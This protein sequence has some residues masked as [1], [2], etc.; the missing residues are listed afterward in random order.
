MDNIHNQWDEVDAVAMALEL[1]DPGQPYSC[2]TWGN[3]FDNSEPLIVH[4]GSPYYHWWEMF[5]NMYVPAHAF[6]D[7]NMT[8]HYKTNTLS[9]YTANQKIEEML[10]DCGECYIDGYPIGDN[11]TS[12]QSYQE[13]CCEEFGGVYFDNGDWDEFYC[14][15]SDATWVR[16]CGNP[17]GDDDGFVTDEDNCPND[18]NPSQDDTDGDGLGDACDDCPNMSGDINDDFIID[19]LDIVNVVNMILTGGINS[20]DFTDCEK[21]DADLDGNGTINILDAIQIINIVLGTSRAVVDDMD[22]YV[23]ASY[24]INDN[25]LIVKLDSDVSLSGI[26]LAFFSNFLLDVELSTV[27]SDIY[28]ATALDGD[29]QRFVAFSME[30]VSFDNNALELTIVDGSLLDIEDINIIAGD[31]QGKNIP[32]RWIAGEVTNFKI[33]D[34]YPNPFNPVTQIEYN[35]DQAGKLSLSVYNILGQEVAVLYNGQQVEG[36]Y[37]VTW[38]ASMFASGV[39]YIRMIMNGQMEITKAML[40]K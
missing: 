31:T 21:T 6:I 25:D 40:I 1:S 32:T 3:Q 33:A 39:Y 36:T 35:V 37:N 22:G 4:G 29:I 18:Y 15:G 14:E 9:S 7:H 24:T 20:P 2:A 5:E 27:R 11:G 16:F 38:D 8:V 19:V 28:K 12:S 34:V 23:N 30:N 13:F 26:E 17:D 10:E